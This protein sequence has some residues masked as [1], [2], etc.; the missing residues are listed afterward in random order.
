[1]IDND[2]PMWGGG[3]RTTQDLQMRPNSRRDRYEIE[4]LCQESTRYSVT[5]TIQ[6]QNELTESAASPSNSPA[7]TRSIHLEISASEAE[8]EPSEAALTTS[9]AL[10]LSFSSAAVDIILN[11]LDESSVNRCGKDLQ[12]WARNMREIVKFGSAGHV[13]IGAYDSGASNVDR[14][15]TTAS[16]SAKSRLRRYKYTSSLARCQSRPTYT[17]PHSA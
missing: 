3:L 5:E 12:I 8:D 10:G 15:A 9:R 16:N 1:M 4:V 2:L 17:Q 13:V 11:L 14:M 6:L 7:A